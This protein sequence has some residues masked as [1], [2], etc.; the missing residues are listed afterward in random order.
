MNKVDT[1][2][3]ADFDGTV[4]SQ[5]VG[6]NFFRHFSGGKNN[7]LLPFWKSGEMSTR[8]CLKREAELVTVNKE[9]AYPFLD[10][11]DLDPGF[12]DFVNICNARNIPLVIISDG[13]DFY[14]KYLLEKFGFADIPAISNKGIF[15]ESGIEIEFPYDNRECD[16][17]GSCK[18]ERIEDLKNKHGNGARVVFIGDG[19]SDACAARVADVLF[20]KKD[21]KEFCDDRNINYHEFEDF[22]E[23][24]RKLSEMGIL[25]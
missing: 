24:S 11:F 20:A 4:A 3:V 23:V 9:Q 1:I 12:A 8:E 10:T 17:C 18:A 2:I 15:N 13:L 7:E 6:Y 25:N 22:F 5:D 16:S 14:I 19:Y 21:L